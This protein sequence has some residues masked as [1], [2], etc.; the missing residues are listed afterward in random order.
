VIKMRNTNTAI[1]INGGIQAVG[2]VADSVV[3][4]SWKDDT[5]GN[6]ADTNSDGSASAPG[7]SDW[8]WIKM[9]STAIDSLCDFQYA[10]VGYG[11][12]R[13]S[14]P[15]NGTLWCESSSP[16]IRDCNFW[17]DRIAIRCDG[18][19]AATI[20]DNYFFNSYSVP[21]HVSARATPTIQNNSY[22]QNAYHA[23]G[24]ISE[25]LASSTTLPPPTAG[26]AYFGTPFPYFLVQGDV[27]VGSG[28]VLTI[29][30][31]VVLKHESYGWKVNGGFRA[32]D[33]SGTNPI[34]FTDI[35]DDG[36]GGDSNV[37]GNASNPSN[38]DWPNVQFNDVSDDANCVI[39]GCEFWYGGWSPAAVVMTNASPT[40]TNSSFEFNYKGIWAQGLS[41]PTITNNLIRQCTWTPIVIDILANPVFGGNV[42]DSNGL[43][44]LAYIGGTLAQDG[45][46][47]QRS[48]AG[49]TN[50]TNVL[51]TSLTVAFGVTLTIDPGVVLKLWS[52]NS[53]YYT[54]GNWIK[55]D[56]A[57]VMDGTPTD[58]ITVTSVE[59][60]TVG[61][62]AD[63]NNDGSLTVPA[64]GDWYYVQ[65]NDVSDDAVSVIDNC[66][67]RYGGR[68][69]TGAVRVQTSGPTITDNS[70]EL[71][72]DDAIRLEGTA[73]PVIT[74]NAISGSTRTPLA[75]S[76]LANPTLSGN[77]LSGNYYEA[78]GVLGETLAQDVTWTRRDFGGDV[79][80]EFVLLSTLTVGTGSN[81]TLQKG[82]VIKPL[83]GVDLNVRRGLFAVGGAEPESLIV[84]T[85]P[86]DDFYGGDTNGDSTATDGYSLRWG[87]IQ[88]EPTALNANVQFQNCVFAY[89]TTS[90]S[91][92]AITVQGTLSP[93]IDGCIF[94]HLTNGINYTQA[95]G[96]STKGK[97][98]DCDFF[99]HSAF[100]VKNTGLAHTVSARNC[101][102]GDN[103]GP[104]HASNPGGLGEPITDMVAYAPFQGMGLGNYHLGD[105]SLNGEVRAYDASLVLQH[106]VAPFL[107]GQ[108]QVIGDVTCASGLT[109][110][111]AS[112]ILQWVAQL[113]VTFPCLEIANPG[114]ENGVL[115]D[116]D[117]LAGRAAGGG[118]PAVG[119]EYVVSLADVP[120]ESGARI[121]VPLVAEGIGEFTAAQFTLR[122]DAGVLRIVEIEAGDAVGEAQFRAAIDDEGVARIAAAGLVPMAAGALAVLTV[123]VV[124]APDA[125][126]E[127][128]IE[129][130]DAMLNEQ[131]VLG[132]A[133]GSRGLPGDGTSVAG[134]LPTR[135][136]LT[137]NRPNPVHAGAGTS[138]RFAIPQSV[139]AAVTD[140]S[141]FG[142]D[143]RRVRTLVSGVKVAGEH[144]VT[145]DG[146]DDRG[147][148]VA[149][150]V[151][152]YRLSAGSFVAQKKLVL[153]K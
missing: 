80:R 134:G 125:S 117:R 140:L 132:S 62:P 87:T 61:N 146:R 83:S 113:I 13:S 147:Q 66:V 34:V 84:F 1:N 58:R 123:E 127:L 81:L 53:P 142:V 28:S 133:Q 152:F 139:D 9:T 151:Y 153:L 78:I 148:R 119:L 19:S 137:Q 8:S 64:P 44:A 71:T 73:D 12:F 96:D 82:L 79:N 94:S 2:A 103:T 122:P 68:G 45:T 15:W 7:H 124:P 10:F 56:G 102:W 36:H 22:D 52:G 90:T 54:V 23:L 42:F 121:R 65:F 95:S 21:I 86:R 107:T 85:S 109:A 138:I 126:G 98:T 20:E 5:H 18:N 145:W 14:Q 55:I 116:G 70:F 6:P 46:I 63:T 43:M 24:L 129:F 101:W 111:D 29:S 40:I 144:E 60:D 149:S 74:G 3:F 99:D 128:A 31:G 77:I 110:F 72:S 150:G 32:E 38:G 105:V 57:L 91:E 75:M 112:Q 93:D 25:T 11:G 118:A 120:L 39:D 67:L 141:I 114:L 41:N 136:S 26:Q 35:K 27:T 48:L 47:P 59:D 69:A 135:F 89:A 76:L 49:Y 30:P 108:Q 17:T 106:L 130:L 16:D 143:G 51:D 115:D 50:I 37:D 33:L 131:D 97:V 92:G 100:A 104:T 88:I 4:T